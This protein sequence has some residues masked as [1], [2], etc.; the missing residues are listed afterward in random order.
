MTESVPSNDPANDKTLTGVI[1]EAFKKLMQRTEDMLPAKI[2]TYD[3]LNNVATVQP[4]IQV[5]DTSGALTSRGQLAKVPVFAMGSGMALLNFNLKPG[6]LGWIKAND[7]DISLFIQSLTEQGPNTNRLHQ[8]SD[9][10]FLPDKIRDFI[11]IDTTSEA[12]LQTVDGLFKVELFL[13]R[14]VL[15]GGVSSITITNTGIDMVS[16]PGALRHNGIPVGDTHDHGGSP[17]APPGPVSDTGV[18]NP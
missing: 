17:T 14:L 4:L 1:R 2:I 15:T 16:P 3:R 13:D 8:F 12:T 9:G 10:V 6:D 11:I 5:R 7:R 18:P